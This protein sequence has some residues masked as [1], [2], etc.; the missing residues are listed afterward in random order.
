MRHQ[1]FNTLLFLYLFFMAQWFF[2]NVYEEIVMVPNHLIDTFNTLTGYVAYFH[3]T[4]PVFYFVPFTQLAIIIVLILY[5]KCDEMNQ[6]RLLKKASIFGIIAILLT[7]VIVTQINVKIF[8]ANFANY[9]D[10]LYTL[11][12]FWLLGNAVRIFLVGASIYYAGKVYILRQTEALRH[13]PVKE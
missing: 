5:S 11:S 3:I 6:K 9:Q 10:Q 13:L 8:S 7:V 1:T 4:N 2:G 12:V